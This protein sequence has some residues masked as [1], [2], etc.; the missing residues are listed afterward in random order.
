VTLY[1]A[2]EGDS[3]LITGRS[4]RMTRVILRRN[5]NLPKASLTWSR[6]LRP[7]HVPP[8]RSQRRHQDGMGAVFTLR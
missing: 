4:M 1:A 6:F 2:V 5:S 7:W 3:A 8:G